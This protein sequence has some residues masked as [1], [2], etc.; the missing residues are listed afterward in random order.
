MAALS[1]HCL[2]TWISES[3][4]YDL[5][6]SN[7]QLPQ[8]SFPLGDFCFDLFRRI[9]F[10]HIVLLEFLLQGANI[11]ARR[12]QSALHDELLASLESRKSM[13]RS[14]VCGFDA[15]ANRA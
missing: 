7:E 12:P 3:S 9:L 5:T 14:A 13:K 6:F 2:P 11:V 10:V 8:Q 4:R 15:L 1:K